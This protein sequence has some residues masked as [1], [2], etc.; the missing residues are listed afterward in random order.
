MLTQETIEKMNAMKLFGLVAAFDTQLSSSEYD[1]LSFEERVGLLVDAEWSDRE[2]RKLSRRLKAAKLRY[3]ASLENVNFQASRGLNR[4]QI[5]TLGSGRWIAEQH[6]LLITGPT[7][8]RQVFSRMRLR[9]AGLSPWL[10][11][12]LRP[13][14]SSRSR[15]W[16]RA[17]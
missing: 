2:C 14:I 8:D 3:P 12:L 17:R 9:R 6:N 13:C 7:G 11:R 10:H 4:Q 15:P 1:E 16:R 5:L